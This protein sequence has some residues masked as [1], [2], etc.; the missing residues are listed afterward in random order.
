M[1]QSH[2]FIATTI[3]ANPNFILSFNGGKDCTVVLDLL[4]KVCKDVIPCLYI[5]LPDT[6]NETES[7][8]F[9][10]CERYNM[11]LYTIHAKTIKLG[12]LKFLSLHNYSV[13]FIG[14]R[15]TDPHGKSMLPLQMTDKGWPGILRAHPILNWNLKD[16]WDYIL[17]YNV[18]YCT[19]YDQGYSSIGHKSITKQ[20]PALLHDNK[21]LPAHSLCIDE[22]E[23]NG[24]Q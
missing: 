24:R 6:F 21:Y 20:N 5:K 9:N 1:Q 11:L 4:S 8:I 7:F 16:I 18:K 14:T 10:C 19:L 13:I 22:L 3:Q 23:R 12:L 17:Q 2:D 15:S